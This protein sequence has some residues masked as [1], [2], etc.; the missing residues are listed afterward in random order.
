VNPS[1]WRA[2]AA[3][4]LLA[5]AMLLGGCASQAPQQDRSAFLR[6]RPATLLVLPPVNDSVE[7]EASA[8][9]WASATR[10]LAEA[11]YYVLPSTLVDETLR[12]NGVTVPEEAQALPAKKLRE[13]FGADAAVY[14]K[15]SRY[16]TRY[17]VIASET[18]VDVDAR[19]V[20]LR[21]GEVLWRGRGS[22]SSREDD[23]HHDAG[24]GKKKGLLDTLISAVIG[25][26]IDTRR[27]ASFGYAQQASERMFD[28]AQPEGVLA[29]PRAPKKDR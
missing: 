2:P 27:N 1:R 23:E 15:V 18:R 16:G 7:I 20:D 28:P 5:A 25:Q 22:A 14:I 9:A 26:I 13:V 12:R 24:D 21:S 4:A 19:I 11:G 10:P 29:G 17:T 8:G 3:A 6:A